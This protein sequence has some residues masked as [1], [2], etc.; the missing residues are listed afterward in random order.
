MLL[1]QLPQKTIC[2]KSGQKL[3][4]NNHSVSFLFRFYCSQVLRI[5]IEVCTAIYQMYY[6][7]NFLAKTQVY[8]QKSKSG[9]FLITE[10]M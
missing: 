3:Q 6:E 10:V 7:K 8:Y 4:K 9:Q 5:V 1:S 2:F